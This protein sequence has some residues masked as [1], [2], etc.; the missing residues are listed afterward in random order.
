MLK[1]ALSNAALLPVIPLAAMGPAK[2]IPTLN[3]I[4]IQRYRTALRFPTI[5]TKIRH[6]LIQVLPTN[7]DIRVRPV[8]LSFTPTEISCNEDNDFTIPIPWD[9]YATPYIFNLAP[10]SVDGSI[11]VYCKTRNTT[12]SQESAVQ[13]ATITLDREPPL[14]VLNTTLTS[15][16]GAEIFA[17]GSIQDITWNDGDFS[18]DTTLKASPVTLDYSTD[19]GATFPTLANNNIATEE[20]NDGTYA[21]EL[22]LIESTTV[23]VRI[24][25]TDQAGNQSYDT[26]DADF[27][28]QLP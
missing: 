15:P 4:T 25:V 27:T 13:S 14:G 16:N 3:G 20:D 8:S 1:G 23:Q 12:H 19:S 6:R 7:M 22:P 11:T 18:A 21:W 2:L 26:S 10:D 24:T 5:T 28:I 17:Q 9:A